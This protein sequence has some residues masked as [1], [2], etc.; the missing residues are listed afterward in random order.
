ARAPGPRGE[1][2]ASA[3]GAGAD[4]V[5]RYARVACAGEARR[6]TDGRGVAAVYDGV[7]KDTFD[8]S[9]ASLRPRGTMALYGGSS[10]PV[11]PLDP[12]RLNAGGSL[13]LTRPSLG[14]YTLTREELLTRAAEAFGWIAAG[15]LG[16]R[17]GG[18]SPL[19]GA[20]QAH[21]DLQG[22]RTT[23]KLLLLPG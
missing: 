3:P 10:G 7:G 2:G 16:V 20:G 15:Q 14:H 11:P 21:E 19:D 12:Q 4:G 9:L 5:A 23:G 13:Y 18:R 22:R 8:G 1:R 6:L 17:I